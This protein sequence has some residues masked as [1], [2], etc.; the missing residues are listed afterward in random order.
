MA[1]RTRIKSQEYERLSE[2]T[3]TKLINQ[4]KPNIKDLVPSTIIIK[5]KNNINII[6]EKLLHQLILENISSFMKELGNGYSFI[7]SE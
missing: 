1:V 3:K 4:E 5:N 6:N 7:D 2:E